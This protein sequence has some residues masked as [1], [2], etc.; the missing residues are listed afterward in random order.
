[1][2]LKVI[3]GLLLLLAPCSLQAREPLDKPNIIFI[4]ADD[5]GYGD[6]GC[7]GQEKIQT[8]V[9]DQMARSGIQ[10]RNFYAGCTVCASSR[11]VLMTGQHMG[12][13]WVRGNAGGDPSVQTL[14]TSDVTVAERLKAA[15]YATALCGKWGLG[16]S[17]IHI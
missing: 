17:L 3:L 8:P 14:R 1:M 6:L 15:G 4:M 5:L 7:Y 12:H 11:S 10:F 13:T 16:L 2:R 9:L